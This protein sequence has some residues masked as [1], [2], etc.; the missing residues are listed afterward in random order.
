MSTREKILKRIE[1]W[2]IALVYSILIPPMIKFG[3]NI[4]SFVK[5]IFYL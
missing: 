1:Q 3:K 4:Y 5:N 2:D